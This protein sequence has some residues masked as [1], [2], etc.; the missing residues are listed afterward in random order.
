VSRP[1]QLSGIAYHSSLNR[2][3]ALS[4]RLLLIPSFSGSSVH[5]QTRVEPFH[6]ELNLSR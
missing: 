5:H 1:S 6:P 4:G 3:S 2:L